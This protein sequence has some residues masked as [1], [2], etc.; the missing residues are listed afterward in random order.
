MNYVLDSALPVE[1]IWMLVSVSRRPP[2]ELMAEV[3]AEGGLDA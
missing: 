1:T 2:E 3:F